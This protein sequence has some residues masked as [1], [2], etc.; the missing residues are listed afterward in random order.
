[1]ARQA[2]DTGRHE[3]PGSPLQ[4]VLVKRVRRLQGLPELQPVIAA[5]LRLEV[6]PQRPLR[7][8]APELGAG[9]AAG[10][11]VHA[12]VY[13]GIDDLADQVVGAFIAPRLLDRRGHR[14]A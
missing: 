3:A 5:S 9:F 8:L 13:A 11:E 2:R 1:M 14:R 12:A 6:V 10:S 7:G 4:A